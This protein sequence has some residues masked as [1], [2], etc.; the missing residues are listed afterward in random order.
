MATVKNS[1]KNV[2]AAKGVAGGYVFWA[3]AGTALPDDY[4]TALAET[5]VNLGYIGDDGVKF[6][7]SFDT[8]EHKDMNGDVIDKSLDGA[9]L[10]ISMTLVEVKAATL[11][12]QYGSAN[13]TDSSGV[14]KVVDKLELGERCVLVFQLLLKDGRKMRRVCP[15]CEPTEL[16]EET[17]GAGS[18]FAR[19]SKWAAYKDDETGGAKIDY[20]ESTETEA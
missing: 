18:L 11:K 20:I 9:D 4:S 17:V 12:A 6:T 8:T 19:E 10:E 1:K 2:S 3:P 13:V 16:G 15:D 7:P 5:Y 14:L